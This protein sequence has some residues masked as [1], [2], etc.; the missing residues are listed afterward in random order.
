MVVLPCLT[1]G[2]VPARFLHHGSDRPDK[3]MDIREI[4]RQ[5]RIYDI[6]VDFGV[7]MDQ[8]IA[9]LRQLTLE[10]IT[11]YHSCLS[12]NRPL[13][14]LPVSQFQDR[15]QIKILPPRPD[16]EVYPVGMILFHNQVLVFRNSPYASQ[17]GSAFRN[18]AI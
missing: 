9:K 18:S 10:Q 7:I 4:L 12:S 8:D 13:N 5:Y 14:Q 3:F 17:F 16:I 2:L 6:R 15:R 1:A 11:I